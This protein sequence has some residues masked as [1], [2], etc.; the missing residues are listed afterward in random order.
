MVEKSTLSFEYAKEEVGYYL[1]NSDI[2]CNKMAMPSATKWQ[3]PSTKKRHLKPQKSRLEANCRQLIF[4]NPLRRES[5]RF[6]PWDETPPVVFWYNILK[7][8]GHRPSEGVAVR[9][10]WRAGGV[11]YSGISWL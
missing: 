10:S 8:A 3:C 7:W 9:P 2:F 11:N 6:Q 1:E 5:K 4:Y